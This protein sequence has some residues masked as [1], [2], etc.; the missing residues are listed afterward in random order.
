MVFWL[1]LLTTLLLQILSNLANDYGDSIHGADNP[2]RVGPSRAVQS[3]AIQASQM[4]AGIGLMIV[5]SLV[6]GILLILAATRFKIS[7]TAFGFL[8]LGITAIAA[9][10]KYTSGKNPYG[11]KGFGDLSVFLFFG[12]AGVAGTYFLHSGSLPAAI[13]LPS[14]TIGCWS[15]AVLNLNNMRDREADLAAGK[16]T[17]AVYLGPARSRIYHYIIILT[18]WVSIALYFFSYPVSVFTMLFFL[19]LPL[20][21][22]HLFRVK[23]LPAGS[24]FDPE[25]KVVALSTFFVV[26]IYGAVVLWQ[27]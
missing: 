11:Y 12:L 1:A 19:P 7:L 6:S 5:L 4:K 16:R 23:Q 13:L 27:A 17:L 2:N 9:A 14:L 26:L 18:G 10:I 3:G 25:L 24:A 20:F 22:R 21:I 15:M 8:L